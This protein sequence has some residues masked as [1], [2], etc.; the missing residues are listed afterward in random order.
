MQQP[1]GLAVFLLFLQSCV[2]FKPESLMSKSPASS[3]H[4]SHSE[5]SS[6]ASSVNPLAIEFNLSDY[7]WQYRIMLI[8]AASERSPAYQQQLAQWEGAE[9]MQERQLRLVEVWGTGTGRVDGQQISSKS[10]GCLRQQFGITTEDFAVI[11]V[12][13]DG[14]EKQRSQVPVD[15]AMIF[16]AIDAMPM[17][18]QEMRDRQ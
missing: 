18:Q 8:F 16:R 5:F 1:I 9:G 11:L 2:Y 3:L 12:G 13:K 10:A 4:S 14:T 17:R 15:P 6:V 7:Q